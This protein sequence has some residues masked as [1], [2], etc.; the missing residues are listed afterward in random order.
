MQ[1]NGESNGVED[2]ALRHP[3]NTGTFLKTRDA[4]FMR[5]MVTH[6]CSS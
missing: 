2:G 5:Q 6:A 3:R 1:G 4:V